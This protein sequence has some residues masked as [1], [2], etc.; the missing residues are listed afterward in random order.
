MSYHVFTCIFD[1]F[2][3]LNRYKK[4]VSQSCPLD[5]PKGSQSAVSQVSH[6]PSLATPPPPSVSVSWT[7]HRS[8][9]S[10]SPS[11]VVSGHLRG[12][13][14]SDQHNV[15]SHPHTGPRDITT[16][17]L[18]VDEVMDDL[19]DDLSRKIVHRVRSYGRCFV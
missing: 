13:L 16:L 8:S 1:H 4:T 9:A 19:M 7:Q 18:Q 10:P 3:D 5:P 11:Q 12:A 14:A 15:S 17:P 6:A 2:P